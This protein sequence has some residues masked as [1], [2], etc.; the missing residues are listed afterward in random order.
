MRGAGADSED[1]A[2]EEG[3]AGDKMAA[4]AGRGEEV[5]VAGESEGGADAHGERGQV[6][7]ERGGEWKADP[8]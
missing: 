3:A 4:E 8:A 5:V 6:E 2:R 1:G 7:E